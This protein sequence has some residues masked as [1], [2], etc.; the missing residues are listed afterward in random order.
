E[1]KD[2]AL[3]TE[4]LVAG[5]SEFS[6]APAT[7]YTV[8]IQHNANLGNGGMLTTRVGYSYSDQY[9]RA[10]NP[11][12]RTA[13]YPGVPEGF[14]ETGDFGLVNARIAYAPADDNWEFAVFGTN[15]TNEWVL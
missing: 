15:L 14:D 2:I 12:R 11:P 10:P 9:W 5:E 4:A 13:W 3:G 7:T 8:G 6:R 1:Y